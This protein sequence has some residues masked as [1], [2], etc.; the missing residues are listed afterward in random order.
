M[1]SFD[2]RRRL[3]DTSPDRVSMNF[4]NASSVLQRESSMKRSPNKKAWEELEGE[5]VRELEGTYES[6]RT[7]KG[8]PKPREE[9]IDSE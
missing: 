5:S 3:A 7:I 1:G 9:T 8:L 6:I 2:N 4:S